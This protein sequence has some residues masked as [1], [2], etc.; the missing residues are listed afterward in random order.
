MEDAEVLTQEFLKKVLHYNP[1]TG[2][3]TWLERPLNYF[4]HCKNP[5]RHCKRWNTMFSGKTAGKKWTNKRCKVFYIIIGIS[6]NGKAKNYKAHRLAILYTDGRFPL[7]DVDHID[8]NG[9]NNHRNNLREVSIQENNKNRPMPSNNNSGHVGVCWHA[10]GKKWEVS[11]RV[12]GKNKYG[13]LFVNIEDA[14]AKRKEL[15]IE[16]GFHENHG[17][18]Q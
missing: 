1:D 17:R 4:S 18:K 13:G 8:G 15:E 9:L 2:I 7:E 6:I 16:Y 10:K 5:E 11:I 14:I 12:K 3:F